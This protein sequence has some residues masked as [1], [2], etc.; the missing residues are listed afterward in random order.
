MAGRS[1]MTSASEAHRWVG[2]EIF[3]RETGPADA[4]VV[5]LPHGYPSS[6]FQFR[7]LMPALGD[8]WRCIAPDYPG[9]GYRQTPDA[10]A[11]SYLR[12]V[13]RLP[14]AVR[15]GDGAGPLRDLPGGPRLPARAANGDGVSRTR[16]PARSRTATSTRTST[17]RSTRR[18]RSSGTTRGGPGAARR[19]RRRGPVPGVVLRRDHPASPR[20]GE[21]RSLEAVLV[22]DDPDEWRENVLRFVR[23]R[24]CLRELQPRP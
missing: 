23:Q 24:A 4:P 12:R 15:A 16:R 22:G 14:P 20:T 11:F 2:V 5:L 21:P 17:G 6:S 8:R 13:R 7:D 18:R 9:F 3:Y 10:T 1:G 19:V